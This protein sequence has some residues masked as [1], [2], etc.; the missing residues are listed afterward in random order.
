MAPSGTSLHPTEMGYLRGGAGAAVA[1]AVAELRSRALLA[2][3]RDRR[4]A[5]T[6]AAIPDGVSPLA[7]TVLRSLDPPVTLGDLRSAPPVR[8]ALH[9]ID[10]QLTAAGLLTPR[11]RGLARLA[12]MATGRRTPA[13]KELLDTLTAQHKELKPERHESA[14]NATQP[15]QV[16]TSVA[17]FGAGALYSLDP[18]LTPGSGMRSANAEGAAGAGGGG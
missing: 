17:L 11:P 14:W 9:T 5:P 6:E 12:A 13:G 18:D 7:A 3:L 16:A 15:A 1:T 4:L 2:V 10:E 8:D